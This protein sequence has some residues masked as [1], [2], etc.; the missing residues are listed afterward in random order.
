MKQN[1]FIPFRTGTGTDQALV[2][3]IQSLQIGGGGGIIP[4]CKRNGTMCVMVV[5]EN[6][7]EE[8]T[9]PCGKHDAH[10]TVAETIAVEA[11]E[12]L[13]FHMG[14]SKNTPG[15]I[16]KC[17]LVKLG[18][19]KGTVLALMFLNADFSRGIVTQ[20]MQKNRKNMALPCAYREVSGLELVEVS[21]IIKCH[22][23]QSAIVPNLA[24]SNGEKIKHIRISSMCVDA[25]HAAYGYINYRSL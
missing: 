7:K 13:G 1:L 22:V 9:L 12:E 3:K 15:D 21:E 20:Q 18:K 4:L 14:L 25:I 10:T 19:G 5:Y 2:K 17:P 6:S 8:W 11:Y 24:G 16:E 23:G